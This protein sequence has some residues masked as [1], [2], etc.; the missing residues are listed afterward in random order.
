MFPD[1]ENHKLQTAASA[2]GYEFDKK[3]KHHNALADAEACAKIA[4]EVFSS[5]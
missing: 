1:L 3:N 4:M 5:L 2:C